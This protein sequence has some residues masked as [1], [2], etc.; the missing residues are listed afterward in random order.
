MTFDFTTEMALSHLLRRSMNKKLD[1]KDNQIYFE[2]LK[3]IKSNL[4][5]SSH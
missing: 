2:M 4:N 1:C 5:F 3:K